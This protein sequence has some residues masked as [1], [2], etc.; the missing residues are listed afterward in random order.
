VVSLHYRNWNLIALIWHPNQMKNY[1]ISNAYGPI[2]KVIIRCPDKAFSVDHPE[3]WNYTSIPDVEIARNEHRRIEEILIHSGAEI[4]HHRGNL[5]GHADS[6]FVYDPALMTPE[7]AVILRM[8]KDLRRGEED[9][10][11][12]LLNKLGIPVISRLEPPATAEGG[13]LLWLNSRTL[14]VGQGFRTNLQAFQQLERTLRPLGVQ[15][16]PVELPYFSGPK[17]CLHLLSLISILDQNLAVTYLPL[18]PVSFVLLLKDLGF[19]L[20]EVPKE[21][22]KTMG[23]NVLALSPKNCLML[24]GNPLTKSRLEVAGCRVQT[25]SGNELSLKAEGGPTCLTFPIARN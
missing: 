13:D 20:I 8:G 6:I 10:M 1:G 23:P 24:E 18:L 16:V 12:S 19:Q 5:P 25:Y 4:I 14:A 3:K 7:G 11:A 21:E 22:F 15:L 17:A 9:A 2:S